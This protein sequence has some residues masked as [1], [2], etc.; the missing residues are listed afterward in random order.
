M[1]DF[2]IILD[3]SKEVIQTYSDYLILKNMGKVAAILKEHKTELY[4]F[5]KIFY[6]IKENKIEWDNVS[7]QLMIK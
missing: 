7:K 1:V 6:Y 4:T 3:V 5:S 2:K